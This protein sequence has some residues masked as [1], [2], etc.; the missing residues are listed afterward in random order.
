MRAS[1]L[2]RPFMQARSLSAGPVIAA[3][4]AARMPSGSEGNAQPASAP[5]PSHFRRARRP[6][7]SLKI[8][9]AAF[10]SLVKRAMSATAELFQLR[11]KR[12][13]RN[14]DFAAGDVGRGT[15][16]ADRGHDASALTRLRVDF[17]SAAH[18]DALL[19]RK[20]IGRPAKTM[21]RCHG[22]D[23]GGTG[24]ARRGIFFNTQRGCPHA[25]IELAAIL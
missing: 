25:S 18:R 4:I 9:F 1:G 7:W 19:D 20:A 11:H 13:R 21:L 10:F 14:L 24:A 12:G 2:N 5:A 17:A 15:P 6:E 23:E 22:A 8:V 16:N 3:S